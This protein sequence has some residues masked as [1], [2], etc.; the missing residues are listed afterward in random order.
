MRGG[1]YIRAK[2]GKL[3]RVAFTRAEAAPDA[4]PQ[5]APAGNLGTIGHVDHGEASLMA[6]ITKGPAEAGGAA[7]TETAAPPAKRGRTRD[8]ES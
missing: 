5:D 7:S 8:K 4:A 6:A 1:S 3:T 2:D